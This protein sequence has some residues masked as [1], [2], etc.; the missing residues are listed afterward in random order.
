MV[1]RLTKARPASEHCFAPEAE[2]VFDVVDEQK[3][4]EMRES[5]SA[6][7]GIGQGRFVSLDPK[8]K[9]NG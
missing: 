2:G 4:A 9:S 1:Q 6:E 7:Y 5:L 8:D 3:I